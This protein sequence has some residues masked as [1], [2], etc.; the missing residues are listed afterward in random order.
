[1]P[2]FVLQS[3]SLKGNTV[4][5]IVRAYH[6]A[7]RCTGC[8]E[9]E[10]VCP[11]NIPISKLNKKMRKEVRE[12]FDYAAGESFELKPPLNDFKEKDPEGFIM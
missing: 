5:N 6:L 9:C 4:W 3:T 2:Q 12:L 8:G 1:V 11:V 7:G 10:R